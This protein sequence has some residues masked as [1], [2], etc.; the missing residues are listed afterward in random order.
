[1]RLGFLQQAIAG[2]AQA[3]AYLAPFLKEMK[4]LKGW[5]NSFGEAANK[6]LTPDGFIHS[7]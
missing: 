7:L 6:P 2:N 4:D 1:M 3:E 5:A